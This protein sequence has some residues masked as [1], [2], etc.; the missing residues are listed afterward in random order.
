MPSSSPHLI[1]RVIEAL[2]TLKPDSLLDIGTGFGKYGVLAR[3]YLDYETYPNFKKQIDGIEVFKRYVTPVHKYVYNNIYIGEAGKML[4]KIKRKYD[5][6][7]LLDVLFDFTK[8]DGRKLIKQILKK[9][10][11]LL[12][13]IVKVCWNEKAEFDNPYE[14]F[15]SQWTERE[16]R[17]FGACIIIPDHTHYL[18]YYGPPEQIKRLRTS[19]WRKKMKRILYSLPF[20]T[21]FRRIL[22]PFSEQKARELVDE[23]KTR[24]VSRRKS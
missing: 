23:W 20:A 8:E 14:I 11:A 15:K 18:V 12:L 16:L 9:N 22:N 4:E 3:E 1:G 24:H 10:N 17:S 2:I 19:I 7:L 5:V 13:S 6:V 21:S